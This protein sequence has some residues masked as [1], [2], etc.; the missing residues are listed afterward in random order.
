MCVVALGTLPCQGSFVLTPG[1]AATPRELS[2]NPQMGTRAA[3][4]SRELS[5]NPQAGLWT[6][7]V[8][9]EGSNKHGGSLHLELSQSPPVFEFARGPVAAHQKTA[10]LSQP[11]ILPQPA[12]LPGADFGIPSI[13][14]GI[15]R[16]GR[17]GRAVQRSLEVD[18]VR[19]PRTSIEDLSQMQSCLSQL[20]QQLVQMPRPASRGQ[21]S[22]PRTAEAVSAD[23]SGSH[24]DRPTLHM[25]TQQPGFAELGKLSIGRG[26]SDAVSFLRPGSQHGACQSQRACTEESQLADQAQHMQQAQRTQQAQQ[27]MDVQQAQQLTEAQEA[28]QTQQARCYQGEDEERGSRPSSAG[29]VAQQPQ[30]AVL[31]ARVSAR[32]QGQP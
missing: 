29:S 17:Q 23:H 11:T 1:T 16:A 4:V 12:K 18:P 27:L 3:Q 28:Q 9:A 30:F 21:G 14:F 13:E 25:H 31:K 2:L 19:N 10:K 7:A 5:L 8:P 24:T 32:R 26:S 20:E 6:A 22:R 15:P